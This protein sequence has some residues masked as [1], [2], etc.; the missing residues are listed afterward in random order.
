MTLHH[1]NVEAKMPATLSQWIGPFVPVVLML[2]AIIINH[3][4][5]NQR[6]DRK[7]A[8]EASRFAV[9]LVAELR[10]MLELYRQNIRLIEQ[11]ADYLLSTRSSILIYKGNLGRLTLLLD[12]RA[13]EHVVAVFAQN[14]RIEST[15]AARAN[16][17]CNL[18]Y[19]F[20]TAEA[21]FDEWRQ[22]YEETLE[23]IV[24]ACRVLETQD[25]AAEPSDSKDMLWRFV[26]DQIRF[27]SR[28]LDATQNAAPGFKESDPPFPV[29]A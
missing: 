3:A 4:V 25:R 29:R 23:R 16:F 9:A 1:T 11:K 13:I 21:R 15:V 10:A 22:M 27:R 18:A 12:K 14:E 2:G 19:Q 17:K 7:T 24:T 26:L 8:A 6:T 28:N 5:V 20:Q